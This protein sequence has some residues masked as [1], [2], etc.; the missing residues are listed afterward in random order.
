VQSKAAAEHNSVIAHTHTRQRDWPTQ[1]NDG[2]YPSNRFK[3]REVI[4]TSFLLVSYPFLKRVKKKKNPTSPFFLV[5]FEQMAKTE[6]PH[7]T[8]LMPSKT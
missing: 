3:K 2:N 4:F 6:A 8:A 5:W 1:Q 7:L